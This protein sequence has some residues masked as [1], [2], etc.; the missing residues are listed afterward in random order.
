MK[1]KTLMAAGIVALAGSIA[2]HAATTV[3][4]TGS[5]AVRAQTHASIQSSL[6]AGYT[7]KF[8]GGTLSSANAAVFVG[9]V[10]GAPAGANPYTIQCSWSG[11]TGGI[12]T[13]SATAPVYTVGTLDPNAAPVA[14]VLPGTSGATDLRVAR[15]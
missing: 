2:A 15:I 7:L 11:S 13:V 12:Q 6:A 14:T 8:T 3:I 1:I 5:T 10:T 9:N 4:L